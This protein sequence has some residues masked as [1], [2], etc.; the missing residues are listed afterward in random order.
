MREFTWKAF[1]RVCGQPLPGNLAG[2][3]TLENTQKVLKI[4]RNTEQGRKFFPNVKN[5]ADNFQKH[6]TRI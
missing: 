3:L 2:N 1:S 5:D 4:G 6:L